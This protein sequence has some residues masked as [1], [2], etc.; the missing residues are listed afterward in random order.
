MMTIIHGDYIEK[1]RNALTE[2]KNQYADREIRTL[3]GKTLNLEMVTQATEST[4]L[5]DKK[6]LVVIENA[7]ASLGRKTIKIREMIDNL[8]K[9]SQ[10]TDIVCWEQKILGKDTV[11]LLGQDVR[12]C[13]FTYPKIIFSLLDAL[14]PN[15]THIL[16]THLENLILSE[17]SDLVWNMMINR[18]RQLIQIQSGV[19]PA[20]MQMWQVSRLTNQARAFTMNELVKN[21]KKMLDMEYALKS[22]SS[23]F[24][25]SEMIK[26]WI[27]EL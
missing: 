25:I 19:V 20:K 16:L 1:S 12:I 22:G 2:L 27:L 14:K 4:S 3:D 24:S 10:N 23:P 26:Q 7:L 11:S 18:M 6:I 17:S 21:Y 9:C 15:N 8:K 5:F 13:V